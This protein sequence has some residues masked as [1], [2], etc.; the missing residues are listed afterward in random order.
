MWRVDC[1]VCV[2]RFLDA[3]VVLGLLVCLVC[4]L[5]RRVSPI[6]IFIYVFSI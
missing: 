2:V 6:K 1:G 4:V 5:L 3:L